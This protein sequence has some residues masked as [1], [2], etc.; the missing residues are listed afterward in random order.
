MQHFSRYSARLVEER[1]KERKKM[2]DSDFWPFQVCLF[3]WLLYMYITI[4]NVD[5]GEPFKLLLC[6]LLDTSNCSL[7]MISP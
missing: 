1:K 7:A 3:K 5:W 2:N 6:V 4:T